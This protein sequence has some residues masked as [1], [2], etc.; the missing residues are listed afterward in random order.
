ML[1]IA[2][3]IVGNDKHSGEKRAQLQVLSEFTE[4]INRIVMTNLWALFCMWHAV[5]FFYDMM[6]HTGEKRALQVQS[7]MT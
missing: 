4:P 2:N 7:E 1:E 3:R 5:R 6:I